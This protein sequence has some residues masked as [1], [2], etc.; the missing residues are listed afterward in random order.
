MRTVRDT[1][2]DTVAGKVA[3]AIKR[4]LA[5]LLAQK[6]ALGEKYDVHNEF[7]AVLRGR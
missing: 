6:R 3:D 2:G 7:F 5:V 1:L 4:E